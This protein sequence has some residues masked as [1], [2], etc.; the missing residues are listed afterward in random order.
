MELLKVHDLETELEPALL[1]VSPPAVSSTRLLR[2]LVV[3]LLGVGASLTGVD[4]RLPLPPR[5]TI[6]GHRVSWRA[7]VFV[8]AGVLTVMLAVAGDGVVSGNR[9][10][11][12]T[13]IIA[14]AVIGMAIAVRAGCSIRGVEAAYRRCDRALAESEDI[15]DALVLANEELAEANIRLRTAQVGF[16]ALLTL[17]DERTDGRLR[18]LLERTGEDLAEMFE[19]QLELL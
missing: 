14:A 5:S 17:T 13:A 10:V 6:P 3:A 11:T 8:S 2:G 7:V 1:Q 19:Q 9:I 4:R 15:R 18:E 12:V 16:G